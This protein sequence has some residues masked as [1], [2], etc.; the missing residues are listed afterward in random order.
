VCTPVRFPDSLIYKEIGERYKG[1]Q[2]PLDFTIQVGTNFLERLRS[3]VLSVPSS[4]IPQEWNYFLNPTHSDFHKI[5][6]L[7]SEPFHFDPRLKAVV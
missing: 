5:E 3:A 4:I 2:L 6:F 7:A 1:F